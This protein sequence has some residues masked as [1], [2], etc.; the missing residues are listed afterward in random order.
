MDRTVRPLSV[1]VFLLLF[2]LAVLPASA[3]CQAGAVRTT[4][5]DGPI[6]PVTARY[7]VSEIESASAASASLLVIGIDTPGG[8]DSSMRD[9]IRAIGRSTTPVAVWVGPSGS[10]AASAG[11]IIGLSAHVLAMA[12]GTNIGA[13]HPVSI[14]GGS[15]DSTMSSKVVQD[16]EAYA[17]ALARDRGRNTEWARQSVT[18]SVS[19]EADE[20]VSLGVADFIAADLSTLVRLANGRTVHTPQGE[21][22]LQLGAGPFQERKPDWRTKALALLNDPNIAYV[23]LLLGIYGLFF[24]LSN[25][26]AI[27]PGV[28]GAISLI[29]GLYALSNLSVNYAGLLL[30]LAAVI[31]LVAEIKIPSHG[32]L[33]IGGVIALALGS[34]FLFDSPF[35]F[36]RVSL[37]LLVPAV[38]VT[39]LFFTF[40]VAVGLRAQKRRPASGNEALIGTL[41]QARSRLDPRGTVFI[42][43]THWSAV[44]V[45]PIDAG[46]PVI[47]TG[48]EDL[49]LKVRRPS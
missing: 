2:A 4:R 33:T 23:L 11:C 13:A 45:E 5:W 40:L 48:V 25:P 1:A 17:V 21:V 19:I 38:V 22:V 49:L 27:F 39:S 12:P 7:L 8:L 20:A 35:P 18:R 15:M 34:L 29:L 31:M 16:A 26:G 41:G 14:G 43:G 47:V 9:I 24:E 30:I 28:F 36:F 42:E 32:L 10:R 6:G 3:I 37:S 44:A 46:E